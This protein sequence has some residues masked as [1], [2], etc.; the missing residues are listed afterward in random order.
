MQPTMHPY[1]FTTAQKGVTMANMPM[2]DQ[3][4]FLK[5]T[6]EGAPDIPRGLRLI[7]D[8]LAPEDARIRAHT[9]RSHAQDCCLV[10]NIVVQKH[11]MCKRGLFDHQNAQWHQVGSRMLYHFQRCRGQMPH[12]FHLG[13]VPARIFHR[14]L[15]IRGVVWGEG[16]GGAVRMEARTVCAW[17]CFSA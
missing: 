14:S 17:R 6:T 11:F 16:V 7:L 12:I 1:W 4:S 13:P 9:R 15:E 8:F 10:L 5:I 3:G 2:P